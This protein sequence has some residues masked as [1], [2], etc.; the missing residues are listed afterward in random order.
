MLG[1]VAR[2]KEGVRRFDDGASNPPVAA[3]RSRW[4]CGSSWQGR[5]GSRLRD[6]C[7]CLRRGRS[8]LQCARSGQRRVHA[9]SPCGRSCQRKCRSRLHGARSCQRSRGSCR[10]GARSWQRCDHPGQHRER[11]D[12]RCDDSQLRGGV[13]SPPVE[14]A[15]SG[16]F[17]A[18]SG[19]IFCPEMRLFCSGRGRLAKALLNTAAP[20]A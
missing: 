14:T 16:H 7:S 8:G 3:G 13:F 5:D 2:G 6:G 10:P 18:A 1:P 17:S 19:T 11:D 12:R 9:W 15:A 4:H 20:P